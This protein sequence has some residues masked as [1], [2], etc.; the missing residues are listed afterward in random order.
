M[1]SV[2]LQP[3]RPVMRDRS[4][5]RMVTGSGRAGRRPGPAGGIARVIPVRAQGFRGASMSQTQQVVLI[6]TDTQRF[7]MLG[8]YG[9][10]EMRTP[11]LD[12]LAAGASASTGPIPANRLCGPAR[13]A[14]F[15]GTF[16]LQ[17]HVGQQHGLGRQCEDDWPTPT[18][19]RSAT[20]PTS[21]SGIWMEA[22]TSASA[23]APMAG[24]QEYH[25]MRCY[26]EER[27]PGGAGGTRQTESCEDP[28]LTAEF[29]RRHRARTG[30][31]ISAPLPRVALLPGRLL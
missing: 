7:D 24:I 22:T 5:L 13:S 14:L 9:N 18:R 25:D 12:R 27:T 8:C 31:W 2:R 16:P 29:T 28:G 4:L 15:T 1:A 30:L 26:L 19:P 6:T 17:R 20:P 11:C 23:A 10:P 21:G 3:R